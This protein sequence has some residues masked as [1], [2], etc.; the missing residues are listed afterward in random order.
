M[1]SKGLPDEQVELIKELDDKMQT[2]QN[3]NVLCAVGLVADFYFL[4]GADAA[5]RERITRAFQ[6][7]RSAVGDKLVWGADPKTGTPK[8]LAGTDIANLASWVPQLP[9]DEALD[10]MFHG[11]KKKNDASA[12]SAQIVARSLYPT[13][14]S[15]LQFTLPLAWVA[16]H[17][18]AAFTRLVL[19]VCNILEPS[20]GY[21]GLAAIPHVNVSTNSAGM[22]AAL[23]YISRF[24]G[25]ELDIPWSHGIY[26]RN[27]N[28][29]KG[30]N[31]LTVLDAS[32]VE[33]LGGQE[34]L[35]AELGAEIVIHG[36]SK[37]IVIQA[38][39]QPRYGDVHRQEPM[40]AYR[41]VAK[42][43]L[44]IR[45]KSISGFAAALGFDT[46]RTDEWLRRFD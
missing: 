27:E 42:A 11:G 25:L 3:G 7:Y 40:D 5:V 19:D 45:C 43:L 16:E 33:K 36:Y 17:E 2:V 38:G 21:A 26:M 8:K 35:R 30:I 12:Y 28:A 44:P 34:K 22:K 6:L 18:A 29:I 9:P 32:W 31:W 24:S 15:H 14:L 37:G 13:Y 10:A 20:S 23:G 46:A 1:P 4:N 41:E 39:P